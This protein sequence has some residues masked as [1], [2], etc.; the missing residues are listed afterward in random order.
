MSRYA[1]PTGDP[2][3]NP[4][5]AILLPSPPPGWSCM[6]QNVG[7]GNIFISDSRSNLDG[8][9]PIAGNPSSGFILPAGGVPVQFRRVSSGLW[10]R[11]DAA[12]GFAE[13]SS[14]PETGAGISAGSF[15]SRAGRC[16][17]LVLF[18][19]AL[20]TPFKC[21]AQNR[22]TQ[23]ITTAGSSCTVP[24]NCVLLPVS[25]Q[26]SVS[27]TIPA[28][29][30]FTGTVQF[31]GS[32]DYA[33]QQP[34]TP[35]W[36]PLTVSVSNSASTVTSA[37]APGTWVANVAGYTAV[38][39]RA[40]A[41]SAGTIDKITIQASP[42]SAR[43]NSGGGSPPFDAS[44]VEPYTG[45]VTLSYNCLTQ[46]LCFTV[47]QAKFSYNAV[48][49]GTTTITCPDCN[50]VNAL[51]PAGDVGKIEYGT[52]K[53][54]SV[55]ALQFGSLAVP[56]GTITAVN[57]PTSV[58]VSIPAGVN[59]TG[60]SAILCTFIWSAQDDASVMDAATKAAWQNASNHG[61][62]P[63]R[64]DFAGAIITSWV[65]SITLSDACTLDPD[66]SQMGPEFSGLG[67]N[68]TIFLPP[69]NFPFANCVNPGWF[70]SDGCWSVHGWSIHDFKIDGMGQ[71]VGA[72]ENVSL[73]AV[74]ASIGCSAGGARNLSLSQWGT[75]ASGSRGFVY[76]SCAGNLIN[77]QVENFGETECAFAPTNDGIQPASNGWCF[78]STSQELVQGSGA[79]FQTN[80]FIGD[81]ITPGTVLTLLGQNMTKL[82]FHSTGDYI[83]RTEFN[84]LGGSYGIF[85][86]GDDVTGNFTND[87]IFIPSGS[88]SSIAIFRWRQKQTCTFP[89]QPCRPITLVGFGT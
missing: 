29:D 24:T 53:P 30:T 85:V 59:C 46:P 82:E 5:Q 25:S 20:F 52:E 51:S 9:V 67:M 38:R 32:G 41:L 54:A 11:C 27:F 77:V 31:E 72:P 74:D 3:Q 76:S 75:Q 43:T 88:G 7:N 49:N 36:T 61:C 19:L 18:V 62:L 50:F 15:T 26:G 44:G 79:W 42:V 84:S 45:A 12:G 17:A 1:I 23:A 34:G 6:V 65:P 22:I 71:N 64:A 10:A 48:F 21:A 40:S 86:Y 35:N 28:A 55:Q 8:S 69:P 73:V 57:S 58:T 56:L 81:P 47:H 39:I 14:W 78:G 70:A 87:H 2:S 60:P 68:S 13:V 63:V 4:T 37:T 33:A 83:S 66:A 16:A 80:M 89:R